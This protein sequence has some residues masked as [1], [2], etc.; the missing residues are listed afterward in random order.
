MKH[1]LVTLL[2]ETINHYHSGNRS[3]T[4]SGMCSYF[5]GNGFMCAVGRCLKPEYLNI[6]HKIEENISIANGA[7][8]LTIDDIFKSSFLKGLGISDVVMDEYSDITLEDWRKV[9]CLHDNSDHWN[10]KGLSGA[11]DT[12]IRVSFREEIY[13]QVFP[14]N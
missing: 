12:F 5:S 11:G 2:Q 14:S 4:E 3:S 1:T 6:F 8:G 7:F 10:D 9:Q 13:N